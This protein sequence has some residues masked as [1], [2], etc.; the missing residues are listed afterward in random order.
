MIKTSVYNLA[1]GMHVSK[2]DR[3]WLSTSFFRH[4]FKIDTQKQ[5]SLLKAECEFVFI[6]PD[7]ST[8]SKENAQTSKA[9]AIKKASKEVDK[10]KKL[11]ANHFGKIQK[12]V[13]VNMK[14]LIPIIGSLTNQVF[15]ETEVY[16]YITMLRE[17]DNSLAEKSIRVFIFFLAFAKHIGVKKSLLEDISTAAILHDIGMLSAPEELLRSAFISKDE[18]KYI[19]SHTQIGVELLSREKIFSDLTLTTIQHHHENVDGSGYPDGLKGRDIGLYSR[20]LNI[21]CMYEAL[22]RDRVYRGAVSPIEAAKILTF[23]VDA[24]LDKRL[25][26]KFIEALGIYPLGSVVTLQNGEAY[27][28][29][30]YDK[31]SGY[32][33]V[34]NESK[35][36][37]VRVPAPIIVKSKQVR[38][39]VSVK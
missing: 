37:G 36:E 16:L 30:S 27:T 8:V 15:D 33:V 6:D 13:N 39:L 34:A 11:L 14:V 9:E 23:N 24:K 38:Q 19:E 32:S 5:L 29:L 17:K 35:D 20:M 4:S 7:K 22:T 1:I 31:H 18:R 3:S 2:L 12:G 21:T 25:T 26:L 28:V 10:T